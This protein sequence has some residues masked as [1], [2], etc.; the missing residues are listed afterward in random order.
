MPASGRDQ[1]EALAPSQIRLHQ[2]AG[3]QPLRGASDQRPLAG[4]GQMVRRVAAD[5]Q[6][7]A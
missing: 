4:I 5:D 1:A 6:V 7:G 3:T 2:A